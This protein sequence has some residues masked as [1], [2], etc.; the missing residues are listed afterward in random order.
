[1]IRKH[2]WDR[3]QRLLGYKSVN[4]FTHE[5]IN[6]KFQRMDAVESVSEAEARIAA[7]ESE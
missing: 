2:A 1:M 3:V 6:E 4:A 7:D 5:A